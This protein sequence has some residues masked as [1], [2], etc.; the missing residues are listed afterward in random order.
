MW[1]RFCY[2]FSRL[3]SFPF[4]RTVGQVVV[5]GPAA[6]VYLFLGRLEVLLGKSRMGL[7]QHSEA[8][9]HVEELLDRDF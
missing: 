9:L 4:N 6:G 7:L 3:L 1:R 8:V 5:V 2:R